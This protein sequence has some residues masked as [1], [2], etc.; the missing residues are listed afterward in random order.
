MGPQLKDIGEGERVTEPI[1]E[2]AVSVNPEC[3]SQWVEA[4]LRGDVTNTSETASV[5]KVCLPG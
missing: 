4:S 5:Q 1:L 3:R 2:P